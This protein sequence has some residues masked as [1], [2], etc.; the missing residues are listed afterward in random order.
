M[1]TSPHVTAQASRLHGGARSRHGNDSLIALPTESEK[2]T[3]DARDT[4]LP[5]FEGI[6]D[7]AKNINPIRSSKLRHPLKSTAIGNEPK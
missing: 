7:Y 4:A 5:I 6:Y 3:G 2:S 1:G